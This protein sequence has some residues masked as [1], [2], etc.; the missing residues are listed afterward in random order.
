MKK[1]I[2][3]FIKNPIG[4]YITI[5]FSLILIVVLVD[6]FFGELISINENIKNLWLNL[7]S[8]IVDI[9]ILGLLIN[10]YGKISKKQKDIEG[11]IEEIDDYR[12]NKKRIFG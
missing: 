10:W 5:T 12:G 3:T 4:F 1:K 11:W 6:Y 7:H 2:L 8:S 9:F